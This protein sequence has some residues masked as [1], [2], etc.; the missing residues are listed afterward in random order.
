MWR[1]R[2]VSLSIRFWRYSVPINAE[3]EVPG[4]QIGERAAAWQIHRI[5]SRNRISISF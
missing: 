1:H 5:N 3:K 2:Q 4:E